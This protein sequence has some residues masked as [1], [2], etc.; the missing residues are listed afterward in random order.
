MDD[1]YFSALPLFLLMGAFVSSG[2]LGKEAYQMARVWFAGLKGGLAIATLGGAALFGAISGSSLAGSVVMGKIAY[3]EMRAAGYK[4]P[5][6]AGVISV[7]GTLDLLIPPS[8]AFVIIG[9]LAEL[10]IGKLFMAGILPG[11]LVTLFYMVTVYIWSRI[12]PNLAPSISYRPTW[13]ERFFS[14]KL[15]W[16]VVLLFLLVMGGIYTG[17]FTA[18]EAAAVGAFGA[19]V[20]SVAKRQMGLSRFWNALEDTAKMTAM[21]IILI[22]GAFVFNAFLAITQI[23]TSFGNFLVG[24]PI[25]KWGVMVLIIIF[26][27][28]AGTFFDPNSILILTIP[29]FYPAVDALGFDLIW[30][31]VIMVRLIEIGNISPPGGINLFGLK[32]VIDADMGSIFRGVIPFLISDVFNIIILCAFPIISTFIPDKM[33]G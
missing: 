5:L 19:L 25:G 17:L 3:P 6:A 4:K 10:S 16:P 28:I 7:G 12:D 26:Y 1:Y 20:V 29:I 24:L 23:P 21:I 8:M 30:Y 22:T 2:G 31:S 9:V 27:I 14:L 18:V 32:G 33:L 13:R 15:T 11:I